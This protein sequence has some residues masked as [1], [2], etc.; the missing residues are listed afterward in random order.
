M[1][2]LKLMRYY[3]LHCTCRCVGIA[4]R[5]LLN[6]LNIMTLIAVRVHT[7]VIIIV[8]SNIVIEDAERCKGCVSSAVNTFIP[9]IRGQCNEII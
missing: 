4:K 1:N 9:Q 6:T 5:K 7:Q 2:I 3:V 8:T